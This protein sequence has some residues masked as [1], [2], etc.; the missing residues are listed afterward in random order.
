[1]IRE[2]GFRAYT[3]DLNWGRE[4]SLNNLTRFLVKGGGGGGMETLD[5]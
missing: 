3:Y 5:N 1:M 2:S 4:T